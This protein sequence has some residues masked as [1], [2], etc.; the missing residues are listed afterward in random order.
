MLIKISE[1]GG[2]SHCLV[3]YNE[4]IVGAKYIFVQVLY[5]S[6]LVFVQNH[7]LPSFNFN[8]LVVIFY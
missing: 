2:Y 5:V 1:T 7:V 8:F 3:S 4:P 6:I